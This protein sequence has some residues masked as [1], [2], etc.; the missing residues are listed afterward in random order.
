MTPC[1]V[2]ETRALYRAQTGPFG[3]PSLAAQTARR[4]KFPESPHCSIPANAAAYSVTM[5]VVPPG[6]LAFVTAWPSGYPQPNVSSINSPQARVLANSTV[7]PAGTDGAID[8]LAY[9]NTDVVVDINGYF[10]PDDGKTGLYYFPTNPCRVVDTTSAAFG[11]SL[12]P[13][14]LADESSRTFPLRSSTCLIIPESVKAYAI[15]MTALPN[16]SPMPFLTAWPT[17][18]PRPNASQL[19]AF[20]GQIVSN[21]AIVPA[22]TAGS[23]DVFA[24]RQTDLVIELSGYFS[25]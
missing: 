18:A 7:I 10:A 19:N 24:Y 1:R 11:A 22:G 12:G 2:I 15:N 5:T 13:P 16:N 14:R 25:R 4:F 6:P 3:P 21:A 8:I 9:D 20:D 23:I 17:G